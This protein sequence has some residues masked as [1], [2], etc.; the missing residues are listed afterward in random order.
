MAG[1]ELQ[2]EKNI[3]CKF[4]LKTWIVSNTQEKHL[5]ECV[6]LKFVYKFDNDEDEA[7]DVDS[8]D[9]EDEDEGS[10]RLHLRWGRWDVS[11]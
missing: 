2:D 6:L 11:E 3:S 1:S 4:R 10:C 8:N 5:P 7:D 9:D